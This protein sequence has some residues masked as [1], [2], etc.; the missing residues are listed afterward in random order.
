MSARHVWLGGVRH[1]CSWQQSAAENAAGEKI[2]RDGSLAQSAACGSIYE[3]QK[4]LRRLQCAQPRGE[5]AKLAYQCGII[6]SSAA[7][8]S[9]MKRR[10]KAA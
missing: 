10:R 6:A 3:T 8:Q 5:S 7:S 1:I 9:R 2:I 4:Y